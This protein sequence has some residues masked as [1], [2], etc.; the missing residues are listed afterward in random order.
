MY[1]YMVITWGQYYNGFTD[2]IIEKATNNVIKIK[3][4]L[5]E[6]HK[7][8]E[9][10]K[11]IDKIKYIGDLMDRLDMSKKSIIYYY[12]LDTNL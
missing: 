7:K 9:T 2:D 5:S 12:G 6:L 11:E 10:E 1:N 8:L 4:K 3:E